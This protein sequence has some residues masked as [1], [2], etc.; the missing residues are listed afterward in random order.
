M[1]D[2]VRDV[3]NEIAPVWYNLRRHTIFRRELEGLAKEWQHGRLLNLG[4]GHGPDFPPFTQ[5]FEL[6]GI[7]A[8]I[9]MVR[10]AGQY[11]LKYGFE[12]R[13]INGDVRHLPYA[14]ESFDHAIAVAT[15]HHLKKD[16]QLPALREL[17]RVLKPGG[18]AFITVWN[19]WQTRFWFS[20]S[21]V[22]V[23]FK[24]QEKTFYRY[25]H[26]FSYGELVRL[27]KNAGFK[28]VN[29]YPESGWRFPL[30]FFS[31]NICAVV[32]KPGR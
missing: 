13:L 22:L 11:A 18:T 15:Y 1:A 2:N 4:C 8:S 20:G 6:H 7:D 21:N 31:R 24:V 32:E 23:P 3:F 25:Y 30:K 14:D 5:G 12:A 29:V 9:E 28:L 19:R 17:K 26:L 10:L 27:V 16:D